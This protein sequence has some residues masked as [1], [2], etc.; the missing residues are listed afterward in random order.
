[1]LLAVFFLVVGLGLLT[2]SADH[3]VVGAGRLALHLNIS[4]VVVGAV[5]VGFGT[6]APE[7]LVSATAAARDD[8]DLATG[9]V[10]G[11]VVA[12]LSLVLGVAALMGRVRVSSTTLLR[13]APLSVGGVAAFAYVIQGG[14]VTRTEG[15]VLAVAL[16]GAL[17]W[18]INA[19]R[20][21]AALNR[22]GLEA[23]LED[24]DL[25]DP[26]AID[27]RTEGLRTLAGL[28][29]TVAGSQMLVD[30]A[31][32]IADRAGITSGFIGLSMVAIGTSLPE[33]VTSVAAARRGNTDLIIGSLLGSNMFNGLAI[34]AAMGLIGPGP[35]RDASLTGTATLIMIAVVAASTLFMVTGREIVRWEAVTLSV[36]Y[37][38]SLPLLAIDSDETVDD[39]PAGMPIV[40]L[41][42]PGGQASSSQGAAGGPSSVP[43]AATA[44]SAA[45]T[46]SAIFRSW[47]A[48]A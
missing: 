39:D 40:E 30:G 37:L 3:F 19:S 18:M 35:I 41:L 9:N 24:L 44:A 10:L 23:V 47:G 45:S 27:L 15:I 26:E 48:S 36:I 2:Y 14:G 29:G 28:V 1:M 32:E 7:L 38:V 42:D 16:V 46:S 5:I 20:R 33:L 8:L 31:L 21:D 17:A 11:S 4:A 34:G 22:A 12:N 13:E 25:D 43:G 6:S